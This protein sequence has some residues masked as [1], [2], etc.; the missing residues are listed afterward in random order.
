M[1]TPSKELLYALL[2]ESDMSKSS[3]DNIKKSIEIVNEPVIKTLLTKVK[4]L[5]ETL[6]VSSIKEMGD[7]VA[8][9]YEKVNEQFQT[10][11]DLRDDKSKCMEELRYI[12]Y[13]MKPHEDVKKFIRGF[14]LIKK[15]I[16]EWDKLTSKDKK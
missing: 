14:S 6:S 2:D 9:L 1:I 7:K 5:N 3:I 11:N 15:E 13:E 8:E 12:L 4:E 10:I 16:E